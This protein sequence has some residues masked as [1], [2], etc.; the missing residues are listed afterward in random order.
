MTE[1]I[2]PLQQGTGI[3]STESGGEIII[4]RVSDGSFYGFGEVGSLVWARLAQP[5][6]LPDVL[7]YLRQACGALPENAAGEVATFLEELRG[8]GLL[9]PAGA[10][11]AA[12]S[13]APIAVPG[14]HVYAPPRLDRGTLRHAASGNITHYDGGLTTSGNPGG[15]S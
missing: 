12:P 15:L 14:K 11:S 4:A 6:T 13:A 2:E 9:Q 8:A 7:E 10:H 1:P 5:A 3:L